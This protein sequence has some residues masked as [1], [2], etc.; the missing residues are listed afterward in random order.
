MSSPSAA[1]ANLPLHHGA[2]P[3][4]LFARMRVLAREIARAVVE[5]E[6]TSGF[7]AR[8]AHPYWFQ[9]FGAVL[10]FDWHSSGV[11]T[12]VC[13]ALKDGLK[14][15]ADDDLGLWVAGGK[16]RASRQTPAELLALASQLTVDPA[17]LADTSRLVAR[18]DN[19]AVQDGYTLYHH[20]FVV[21]RAGRWTV[22]QQGMNEA[23]AWAR[24]Y[25]WL[26]ETV[27]RFDDEPHAAVCA[28]ATGAPLNLVAHEG[29]A[30]R[31]AMLTLSAE[32]PDRLVQEVLKAQ[33]MTL[34]AHHEV[35]VGDIAAGRLYKT[36]VSTY[37]NPPADF[38]ALLGRPGVGAKTLRALALLGEL[39]YGAPPSFRDPA[40]FSFAHGG[41]DGTP[42]PVSQTE[43]D[44]TIGYLERAVRHAR[45]GERERLDALRRLTAWVDIQA[46]PSPAPPSA[47]PLPVAAAPG[48]G[49]PVQLGLGAEFWTPGH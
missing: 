49:R 12:V 15:G 42:F 44:R 32:N 6:G 22:V 47:A 34:P 19:N 7:L 24:R 36:L 18:I 29:D 13:G 20:V 4:W 35:Q 25:H 14:D 40:R 17:T 27:T 11:T 8:L 2:C 41:K 45:L 9:S 23:T 5:A 33:S 26:S 38:V 39:L 43:Y 31:A 37:D 1:T 10:G 3:P 28:V 30:N 21:D 48:P 16:G 46:H